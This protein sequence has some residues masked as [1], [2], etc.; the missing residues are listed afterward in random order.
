MADDFELYD[1]RVEIA[2]AEFR[3]KHIGVY[4]RDLGMDYNDEP[5]VS[6]TRYGPCLTDIASGKN[7]HRDAMQEEIVEGTVY[8]VGCIEEAITE[9]EGHRDRL[10]V[11]LERLRS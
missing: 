6:I 11:E 9:L 1:S 3:G 10:N 5:V 2:C 8:V 4:V 7:L